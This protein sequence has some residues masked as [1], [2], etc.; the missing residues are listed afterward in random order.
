[1]WLFVLAWLL[2]I[3]YVFTLGVCIPWKMHHFHL[4]E[5]LIRRSL[6]F[7]SIE[8]VLMVCTVLVVHWKI[9]DMWMSMI[10]SWIIWL[11]GITA[12]L[13][14]MP[15]G[16][17]KLVRLLRFMASSQLNS[18]GAQLFEKDFQNWQEHYARKRYPVI[19]ACSIITIYPLFNTIIIIIIRS[20]IHG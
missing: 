1:M 10:I 13:Y 5:S 9:G 20:Q 6:I 11:M 7:V 12:V 16:G 18:H 19:I 3:A 4:R 15:G 2:V 14:F 17:A 8:L